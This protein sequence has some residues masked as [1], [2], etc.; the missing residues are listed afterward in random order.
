MADFRK[1]A[2]YEVNG[3]LDD[4]SIKY[5]E[6]FIYAFLE[7]QFKEDSFYFVTKKESKVGDL[8]RVYT[9]NYETKKMEVGKDDMKQPEY[10]IVPDYYPIET[11]FDFFDKYNDG[12]AV[13]FPIVPV[14]EPAIPHNKYYDYDEERRIESYFVEHNYKILDPAPSQLDR[15]KDVDFAD[16]SD[17]VSSGFFFDKYCLNS[18]TKFANK[19]EVEVVSMQFNPFNPMSCSKVVTGTWTSETE[20]SGTYEYRNRVYKFNYDLNSTYYRMHSDRWMNMLGIDNQLQYHYQMYDLISLKPFFK[21]FTDFCGDSLSYN[22]FGGRNRLYGPNVIEPI[23]STKIPEF[24]YSVIGP[25]KGTVNRGMGDEFWCPSL[26]DKF[27]LDEYSGNYPC[28]I[29]K[30]FEVQGDVIIDRDRKVAINFTNGVSRNREYFVRTNDSGIELLRL[31]VKGPYRF[32]H[33]NFRIVGTFS[34]YFGSL[35]LHPRAVMAND[36]VFDFNNNSTDRAMNSIFWGSYVNENAFNLI[37]VIPG[38]QPKFRDANDVRLG[39]HI[40]KNNHRKFFSGAK[41]IEHIRRRKEKTEEEKINDVRDKKKEKV[42][43]KVRKLFIE[44][45]LKKAED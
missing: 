13:S 3:W 35:M 24:H 5:D 17:N 21:K 30:N 32:Y 39:I 45:Y 38:E 36:Y 15:V 4:R 28:S 8:S 20:Y 40:V 19:P 23:M 25:W 22:Y 34:N 12:E 10:Q 37:D 1:E 43:Y 16:S 6:D 14:A 9:L 29:V 31:D 18:N 27:K 41:P 33:A 44:G 2:T 42:R 11:V 7:E 26:T